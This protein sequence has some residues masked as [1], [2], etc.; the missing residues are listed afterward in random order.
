MNA[1][2]KIK[3]FVL[4]LALKHCFFS[5]DDNFTSKSGAFFIS[6]CGN[7][8]TPEGNAN[9]FTGDASLLAEFKPEQKEHTAHLNPVARY[10]TSITGI[11]ST[12]TTSNQK[13]PLRFR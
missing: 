6:L 12:T 11:G 7:E 4:K 9:R 13:E 2:L 8:L 3:R 10:P 1:F 5:A